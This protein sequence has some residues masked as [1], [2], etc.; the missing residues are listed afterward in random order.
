MLKV[1]FFFAETKIHPVKDGNQSLHYCDAVYFFVKT[2]RLH[3]SLHGLIDVWMVRWQVEVWGFSSTREHT[4]PLFVAVVAVCGFLKNGKSITWPVVLNLSTNW[5]LI[6]SALEHLK[7]LLRI[8][9]AQTDVN[10][11]GN[12]WTLICK[13]VLDL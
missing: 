4:S 2:H 1:T 3:H 8:G 13:G 6:C 7:I 12:K 10:C 5:P 11:F 9:V